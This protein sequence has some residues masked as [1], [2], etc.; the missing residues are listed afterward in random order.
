PSSSFFFEL[1]FILAVGAICGAVLDEVEPFRDPAFATVVFI[2]GS[3][4]VEGTRCSG[5]IPPLACRVVVEEVRCFGCNCGVV[6]L[7]GD[8]IEE[9]RADL[10]T[11]PG[12][13]GGG[14]SLVGVF[15][16]DLASLSFDRGGTVN[17]LVMNDA[18]EDAVFRD[19]LPAVSEP[20]PS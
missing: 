18:D 1:V 10:L 16:F 19:G 13:G 6:P 15:V 5:R 17:G 7:V 20:A 4:E 12:S 14:N 11:G 2:G 9:T 8:V 3:W